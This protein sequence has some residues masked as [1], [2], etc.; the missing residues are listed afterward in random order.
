M[1]TTAQMLR[2]YPDLVL[3]AIAELRNAFLESAETPEQRIELLAAQITDPTSVQS[4]FDEVAEENPQAREAIDALL[5]NGG[6]MPAPQFARKYGSVRQMGTSKL[7]REAPWL[8]PM[9]VAERLYY[10]GL[11]GTGFAGEGPSAKSII[12]IPSDVVPWL[13][14][15]QNPALEEG[16]AVRPVAPPAASRLLPADDSFL[17]DAGSLIGFLH[18]DTLRLTAEGT[19]D[20][21]DIGRFVQRLQIPF[22]RGAN[23]TE[24]GSDATGREASDDLHTR[25]DLLL[26]V[27]NRLGWLRRGE[28]DA[29]KL[30]VNRVRSFLDATR[31]EQRR[32]LWDAWRQSPDW[33]DLCRTPGLECQNR[34][35]WSNDPLQ[36]RATVL[37]MLATLQPGEWYS[38]GETIQAIQETEPDFQRPTGEYDTWYIRSTT[39]QEYLKGFEQWDAV[40]GALLRFYLRGP[41]HWLQAIDLAEPSAGDD[42]QVSL[43]Q[44]GAHWL[45]EESPQPHE[46]AWQ[47]LEVGEDFSVTMAYGAPLADRFRV[48]RFAFW[49][50][51]DPHYVYQINQRSLQR[52]QQE[53]VA[54]LQVLEFLRSKVRSLPQKVDNALTRFAKAEGS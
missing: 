30:T 9:D 33:N 16:L 51:S 41:L 10:H 17:E 22:A 53:G 19:P 25:S 29:I 4:A 39:T 15:P 28:D 49:Q 2:S 21:D 13:P 40:E 52:A 24:S 45:V 37:H 23:A 36:T 32:M 42:M 5:R 38:Q 50:R 7:E 35:N 20:A 34:T 8:D 47:P 31:A 44:W 54:T 11:I 18:S 26:H 27:G 48:E 1:P 43:S 46:P 12:F 6:E 14:A 3:E